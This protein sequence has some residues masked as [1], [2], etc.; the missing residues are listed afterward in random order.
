MRTSVA[1]TLFFWHVGPFLSQYIIPLLGDRIHYKLLPVGVVFNS[2]IDE[3]TQYDDI[4]QETLDAEDRYF[5]DSDSDGD[6]IASRSAAASE[7][8][9]APDEYDY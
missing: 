7:S 6:D 2:K 5:D 4:T 3:D 9:L 8:G 1:S